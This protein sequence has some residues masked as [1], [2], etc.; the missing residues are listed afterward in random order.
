MK[1]QPVRFPG[2]FGNQLA[3]RIEWPDAGAPRAFAVFAHCFTCSKDLKAVHRISRSLTERGLAVLRFDFSGLGESEGEFA[4]TNFSS[5]LEDLRA[6][7]AFL[8]REHQ[9][10]SLLIGHSLGGTAVLAVAGEF[11]E[12]RAVAT[13]GSPSDTEHV[14]AGLV[15]R[16]PDVAAGDA[17]EATIH[18][19]GRPIRIRRQLLDDLGRQTVLAAIAKLGRPLAV[20]HSP[21]DD[22]VDID[23]ARRIYQTAKH[24]KSFISL[25]NADHLLLRNPQDAFYVGAVLAA[26]AGRYLGLE[27]LPPTRAA[28]DVTG[29]ERARPQH[30]LAHGEVHV[31]GGPSGFLQ[32]I[33]TESHR[34]LG[35]EPIR[36]GGTDLGPTPYD[37]LLAALG[38]C[39]NMTLR[40]Y[41]NHKGL[42]LDG[43]DVVLRH[44][45]IHAADCE[46]CET[47]R[48]KV[49]EIV[50]EITIH[51]D[52]LEPAQ[53]KRLMEI[54]DRCPVHRT[55]EGEIKIRTREG[56]S[57]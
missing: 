33:E 50:R 24:P 7:V 52:D 55:L 31:H 38:T 3:A 57:T 54:A 53:R 45:K 17:E 21:I 46:D 43:V 39:T 5:N 30:T 22:V 6:A 47:E 40:M 42:P 28:E 19:A 51:G 2:A 36:V 29:E 20:F 48:G 23:H 9:P 13:I 27:D 14:R 1:S 25:D 49:D 35:D 12:V 34:F 18:L 44:G 37:L 32:T 15:E 16:A 10:P 11:P 26:W 41:A 4:D 56:D 8:R